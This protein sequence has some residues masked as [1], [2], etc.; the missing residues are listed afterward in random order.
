MVDKLKNKNIKLKL[1]KIFN[2]YYLNVKKNI[3][4]YK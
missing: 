2:Y 3:F 4:K 1:K